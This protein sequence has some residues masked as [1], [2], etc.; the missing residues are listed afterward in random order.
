MKKG[1][2]TEKTVPKSKEDEKTEDGARGLDKED[3]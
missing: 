3:G 1:I 2:Y